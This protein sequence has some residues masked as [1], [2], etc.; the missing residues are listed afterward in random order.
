MRQPTGSGRREFVLATAIAGTGAWWV[1]GRGAA[2]RPASDTVPA[3]PPGDIAV[4][5]FSPTGA[6]AGVVTLAKVVKSD[7]QWR[8]Q[9]SPLAYAVLRKF[10]E[11][12]EMMRKLGRFQ[13]MLGKFGGKMPAMPGGFRMPFGG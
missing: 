3:G 4:A 9:F 5:E 1:V 7:A 12:R 13:K 2:A 8:R 6:A 10:D 11:M